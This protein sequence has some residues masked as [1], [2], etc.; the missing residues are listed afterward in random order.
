MNSEQ[1][2]I[3]PPTPLL[4]GMACH[5]IH[6]A[7]QRIDAGL[8]DYDRCISVA[9]I[10]DELHVSPNELKR[11]MDV[12]RELHYIKF[13]DKSNESLYLTGNGRLTIVPE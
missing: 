7:I 12:L 2:L 6:K 5:T 1:F 10:A 9:A 3:G 11:N 13:T 4:R 8:T